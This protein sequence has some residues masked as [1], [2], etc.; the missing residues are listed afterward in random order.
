[1]VN[2]EK[3]TIMRVTGQPGFIEAYE[4]TAI[5][6][7][8]SG[9]V[10]EWKVDIGDRITK[11]T[12]LA[13][14]DV[15]DL[16]AEHEEKKAEVELDEVRIKVAEEMVNVATENWKMA[17]A[18]VDEAKANLG[19]YA[20]DVVRW[21]ADYARISALAKSDSIE[22]PVEDESYKQLQSSIATQHAAESGIVVAEATRGARKADVAKA[23]IDVDAARARA[24]V[25]RA[26]ERR[27]AATV[28]YATI[29]APYDGIVV[30]RNVNV[31]DYAR[32]ATGDQSAANN[33]P[34]ASHG[35]THPL[36]VVARTDKVRIFLDVPEMEANGIHAG[37]NARVSIQAVDNLEFTAPVTRTSWSLNASS[38]TLRAEIDVANPGGRI[39]PNMYAYGSVELTRVGVWT[40]PLQAV[41]QRGNQHYCYV[42][43]DGKAVRIPVQ[44]GIDDGNWI[45]VTAKRTQEKW[46]PLDGTER[47]VVGDVSQLSNGELV[48]TNDAPVAQ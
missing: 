3:R 40:I 28:A 24:K 37:S 39:L 7:K 13:H 26:T 34:Q 4:Q 46:L 29:K 12:V 38:R 22:K 31:G 1:V 5:F 32:P 21:K 17:S 45:E 43:E 8:I 41:V 9:Y 16:I 27:L 35:S 30:K 25:D 23:R 48:R 6:S 36:Y 2:A 20:A 18:Q 11:D 44:L 42:F 10:D 33:N 19:K 15:P 47:I 14:L